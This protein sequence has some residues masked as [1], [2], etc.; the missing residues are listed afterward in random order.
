MK[1]LFVIKAALLIIACLLLS[2]TR[3]LSSQRTGINS[4]N[5]LAAGETGEAIPADIFKK[6][7]PDKKAMTELRIEKP[8]RLVPSVNDADGNSY[9]TVKIGTQVWITENL[10]VTR[11]ND[12][13][14]I[15]MIDVHKKSRADLEN[16]E[17][18]QTPGYSWYNN[19]GPV[20]KNVYGA[21][22][23]WHAVNTG[24]LC[25]AGWHIP[26]DN[27][28]IVLLNYLGGVSDAGVKIKETGT[29]HWQKTKIKA[30]NE[31]GF[32]ARPGGYRTDTGEFFHVGTYCSWWSSTGNDDNNAWHYYMGYYYSHVF[33]DYHT[34]ENGFS[35]RCIMD[36]SK[37]L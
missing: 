9:G 29:L 1:Q 5:I 21:L 30:T 15:A 22:Y 24:K 28:W 37:P 36:S 4:N 2:G 12:N 34:R 35:V 25:P 18:I 32:T 20:Y 8:Y 27:E 33:R 23:N 14:E 3:E 26:S 13:K 31:S 16:A 6:G 10:K 19:D 7:N 17:R 11:F